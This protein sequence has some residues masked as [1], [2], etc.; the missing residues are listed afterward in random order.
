M[1]NQTIAGVMETIAVLLE[2]K[3]GNPFK[4]R[5]Y[6]NAA[7]LITTSAERFADLSEEELRAV[8]G[9]GKE[10]TAKLRELVNSGRLAYLEELLQE[11]PRTLLD[12]VELQ[13][14]GPKTIAQLYRELGVVSIEALESAVIDGRIHQLRGMGAK[15]EALL[16]R[17]IDDWRRVHPARQPL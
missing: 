13:G 5:A 15:K 6:R 10:L 17:A 8:P 14:V 12:I 2:I 16:L 4:V 9:I 7:E 11:F 1:D 3:G